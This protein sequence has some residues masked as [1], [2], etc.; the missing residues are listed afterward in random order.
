MATVTELSDPYANFMLSPLPP[1]AADVCGVCLTFTDGWSTCY[2]CGH[3]A[4][5]T[6]AVLPISY[7]VTFGQMHT[8]LQQYKRGHAVAARRLQ[9]QLAAVLWRFLSL[10]ERCLA[11]SAGVDRFDLVAT[12]PSSSAERDDAHPLRRLVGELIAPTRARHQ[13]LLV[14]SGTPVPERA[15]EPGQVQPDGRSRQRVDPPHRRHV[16]HRRERPE[17]RRRAEDRGRRSRRRARPRPPRQRRLRREREATEGAAQAVQHDRNTRFSRFCLI[18][19][20]VERVTGRAVCLSFSE[21]L[22]RC[23]APEEVVRLCSR[24]QSTLTE[25]RL[26]IRRSRAISRYRGSRSY[27][28]PARR[29]RSASLSS[30]QVGAE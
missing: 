10:H 17:R 9:V 1:T 7:S 2:P 22:Q 21:A 16:D 6:D 5:F 26:R 14:R 20:V 19:R 25:R 28:L 23:A 12:V 3:Q 4:R 11:R 24:S 27:Q 13:R 8:A 18:A 30:I 15:E 29:V